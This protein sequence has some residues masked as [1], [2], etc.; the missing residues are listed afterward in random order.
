MIFHLRVSAASS[1]SVVRKIPAC[2]C[3]VTQSRNTTSSPRRTRPNWGATDTQA[4]IKSEPRSA[5]H[6][7]P[8]RDICLRPA[9]AFSFDLWHQLILLAAPAAVDSRT[10]RKGIGVRSESWITVT[11]RLPFKQ[12]Q[13]AQN[14]TI[15][16]PLNMWWLIAFSPSLILIGLQGL[17]AQ[18]KRNP[19]WAN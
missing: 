16:M 3:S 6:C 11:R 13:Q 17:W 10:N 14:K 9:V 18:M 8:R 7:T 15:T 1:S 2:D 19:C 12:L 4:R 5:F